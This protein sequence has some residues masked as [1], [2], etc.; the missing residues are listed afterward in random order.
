VINENF[1]FDHCSTGKEYARRAACCNI[2]IALKIRAA[3]PKRVKTCSQQLAKAGDENELGTVM[4][5]PT[6]PRLLNRN[7]AALPCRGLPQNNV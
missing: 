5:K 2:P 1:L 7:V 3:G 4:R 6:R